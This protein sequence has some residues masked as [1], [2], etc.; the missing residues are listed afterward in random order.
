MPHANAGK[1]CKAPIFCT[2]AIK[3]PAQFKKSIQQR[4][5]KTKGPKGVLCLKENVQSK[6][7]RP[8]HPIG[9]VVLEARGITKR[10][11]G[12]VALNDVNLQVCKG[13]VLALIGENGAG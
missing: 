10:F 2:F 11:P 5:G 13:E 3:V 6:K 7:I 12:V 1:G 8:Q 9:P 4:P